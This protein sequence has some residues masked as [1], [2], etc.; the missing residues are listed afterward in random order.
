M[1]PTPNGLIFVPLSYELSVESQLRQVDGGVL[2]KATDEIV[3]VEM[4][5][6]DNKIVY[7]NNMQELQRYLRALKMS[8]P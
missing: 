8:L 3:A 4:S 1:S 7:S 5:V 6:S 2:H